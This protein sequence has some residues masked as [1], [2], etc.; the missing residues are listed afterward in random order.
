MTG[1]VKTVIP[2]MPKGTVAAFLLSISCAFECIV[3][4]FFCCL[5][6]H[7]TNNFGFT[8]SRNGYFFCF[9]L[10]VVFISL[11]YNGLYFHFFCSFFAGAKIQ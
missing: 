3:N 6:I 10:S 2:P 4:A 9:L 1:G 5:D 11:V 7:L 8:L